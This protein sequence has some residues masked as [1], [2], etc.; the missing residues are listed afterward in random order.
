VLN[1]EILYVEISCR[2]FAPRNCR[3]VLI[4]CTQTYILLRPLTR[5]M[6]CCRKVAILWCVH[7]AIPVGIAVARQRLQDH[8]LPSSVSKPDLKPPQAPPCRQQKALAPAP[9]EPQCSTADLAPAPAPPPLSGAMGKLNNI[10]V[11]CIFPKPHISK[12]YFL[13]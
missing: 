10:S 13:C 2:E 1:V 6:F 4:F 3:Y 11:F 12:P 8:T 9:P 7:P 5:F